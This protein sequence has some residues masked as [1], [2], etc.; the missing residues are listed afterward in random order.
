[1]VG[2]LQ[3]SMCYWSISPH[4]YGL[5]VTHTCKANT[6]E[7]GR[8]SKIVS[9]KLTWA[10]QQAQGKLCLCTETLSQK[11]GTITERLRRKILTL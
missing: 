9:L 11:S 7:A 10:P 6:P 1:M 3:E 2:S 8:G 5:G 4:G